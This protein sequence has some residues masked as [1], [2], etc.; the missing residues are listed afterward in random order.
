M[1]ALGWLLNL[2]LR[3]DG[4]GLVFFDFQVFDDELLTLGGV[5]AHVEGEQGLGWSCLWG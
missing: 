5:F 3:A 1:A 4:L 2:G